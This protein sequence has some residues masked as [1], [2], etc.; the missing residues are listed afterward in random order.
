[1]KVTLEQAMKILTDLTNAYSK[2][3]LSD[4]EVSLIKEALRLIHNYEI[5]KTLP[6]PSQSLTA[7]QEPSSVT[8]TTQN[9]LG[10][11]KPK[12]MIVLESKAISNLFKYALERFGYDVFLFQMNSPHTI[13]TIPDY[14]PDIIILGSE[15][16]DLC[17]M[18]R[19]KFNILKNAKIPILFYSAINEDDLQRKV[20]ESNVDGYLHKTWDVDRLNNVLLQ[21]L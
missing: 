3:Q 17:G 7:K 9:I 12:V 15:L 8:A 13:D 21:C 4:T 2:K 1:M 5:E 6:I 14:I 11:R 19:T 16:S 20:K 18:I 10:D